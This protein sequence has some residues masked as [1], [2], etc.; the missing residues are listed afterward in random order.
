MSLQDNQRSSTERVLVGKS[1]NDKVVKAVAVSGTSRI[2]SF[3]DGTALRLS[4]QKLK[5][6]VVSVH[7]GVAR[8]KAMQSIRQTGNGAVVTF[9]DGTKKTYASK[10]GAEKAVERRYGN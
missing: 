10:L 6:A 9:G 2:V 3:E 5:E 7:R 8:D 1:L 4:K